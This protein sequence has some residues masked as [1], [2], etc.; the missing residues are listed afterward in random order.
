MVRTLVVPFFIPHAGC[1]FNCIF[2]DQRQISGI[3]Q[4]LSPKSVAAVVNKHLQTYKKAPS[5]VEVAFFGGSFTGLPREEQQQWLEAASELKR[6]GTINGIR[7]STRPDLIDEPEVQLLKRYGVTSVE[8]GVQSLDDEVLEK[9]R[10]GHTASDTYRAAEIL[11]ASGF[12]IVFQLMLGLPGDDAG[13]AI[14]TAVETVRSRP[15]GVRIYPAL[16][17]KGTMLASWYENGLYRPWT[18]EAAVEMGSVWFILFSRFGIKVLRMGL[19]ASECLAP[20]KGLLAGPYHPAYGELVESR[21]FFKQISE[22]IARA[23]W[24]QGQAVLEV[25]PKDLSKLVGHRKEN[26]H[27]LQERFPC[28]EIRLSGA[29]GLEPGDLVLT[30]GGM[31]LCLARKEFLEKYRIKESEFFSEKGVNPCT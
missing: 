18:L 20:G 3:S 30:V 29:P 6:A 19:Q 11:R 10:R 27:R 12:E 4:P 21:V 26:L 22:I 24:L 13:T 9:S 31:R 2:C 15:D 1:P 7:L 23:G 28:L 8:L 16:V 5:K 17:L 14:K 25:N